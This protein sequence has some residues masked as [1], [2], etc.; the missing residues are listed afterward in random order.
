MQGEGCTE[1]NLTSLVRHIL[2]LPSIDVVVDFF[3]QAIK[4]RRQSRRSPFPYQ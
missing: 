1:R 3:L 4:L 2:A